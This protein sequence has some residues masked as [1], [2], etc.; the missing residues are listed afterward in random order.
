MFWSR[1]LWG[2]LQLFALPALAT[3]WPDSQW[4]EDPAHYDWQAVDR[5]AFAPRDGSYRHDEL[6]KRV[7]AALGEEVR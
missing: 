3:A 7:L 4:L 1:G 6:L 2:C 5:Y